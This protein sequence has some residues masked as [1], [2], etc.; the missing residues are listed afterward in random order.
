MIAYTQDELGQMVC[1]KSDPSSTS[2]VHCD[3]TKEKDVGNAINTTVSMYG[4]LD[5]MLNNAGKDKIKR[6]K[7]SIFMKFL[8]NYFSALRNFLK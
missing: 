2:Y 7:F 5:I 6:V 4:K 1:Q 3:V 8:K